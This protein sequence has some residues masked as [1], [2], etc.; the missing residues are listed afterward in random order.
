[1][2]RTW[3]ASAQS[4]PD[5]AQTTAELAQLTQRRVI[6]ATVAAYMLWHFVATITWSETLGPTV[7]LTTIIILLSA[8]IALRHVTHRWPIAQ[9]VWHVGLGAA[10]TISLVSFREPA[11]IFL[12]ALLPLMAIIT[13]GLLAGLVVEAGI[14]ILSVWLHYG[15]PAGVLPSGFAIS[16]IAMGALAGLLGWASSHAL[17][18][19]THWSIYS[20]HQARENMEAAREHRAQ[21]ARVVKDLDQAYSRLGRTNASL[22][23]AWRAAEE[24]ER[25]KAEFV[26]NVSHELRTPLNL[27]VGFSEMMLTAPESYDGVQI[28]GPYRS[29]LNVIHHNA[30]HL[31]ALVDDVLDLARIEAGRLGLVKEETDLATLVAEATGMVHDYIAA[32][33]LAL[34]IR[35]APDLP[36]IWLDRLRIRQ[37]LL[38]LL[39]NA[40]RFTERG[41]I[42][43]EVRREGQEVI[44]RVTDTGRGIPEHDLPKIFQEFRSTD[45]PVST[46]HSGTGL[47]LPIS[48]RFIE[49]HHGRMGV[50]STYLQGSTFWFALPCAAPNGEATE[51]DTLLRPR[52]PGTGAAERIVVLVHD[53]PRISPLLQHCLEGYRVVTHHDVQEGVALACDLTAMALILDASAEVGPL[54]ADLPIIRAHLPSSRRVAAAMGADDL[55]VKPVSRDELLAAIDRLGRPIQRVLIADDDP[56]VVRLFH[57]MLRTRIARENRLQAH[58]GEEALRLIASERPDLVIL[59]LVMPEK[60]GLGVLEHMAGDPACAQTAVILV[61]ARGQDYSSLQV[62][63]PV[64]IARKEPLQ[65]VEFTRMLEGVLG[66]L[67]PPWPLPARMA[68]EPARDPASEPACADTPPPPASSPE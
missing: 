1:M 18:T 51:D 21:L 15:Q 40:A 56:D 23:A 19:V 36:R 62:R 2:W 37:V 52:L 41:S 13:T 63:G 30:Q 25:F 7:W 64:A 58:N 38:N 67:T 10:I 61:T 48:K 8:A 42:T 59:D 39:V 11:V 22:V 24:A 6:L 12:Y 33:G 3:R 16:A 65:F 49:L 14:V 60:D 32:K 47:G 28:P 55:L 26:T 17:F 29:D 44:T 68:P 43:L 5:L 54:P 35:V 45:Q 66:G 46:W 31:L 20:L 9:V 4:D 57:R 34:H 50:E 27:I 53:D